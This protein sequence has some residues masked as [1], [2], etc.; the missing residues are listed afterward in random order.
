MILFRLYEKYNQLASNRFYNFNVNCRLRIST[1]DASESKTKI[2]F[3]A[4]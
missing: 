4:R 2:A 3:K 1:F